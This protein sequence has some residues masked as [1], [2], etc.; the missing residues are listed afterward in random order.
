LNLR[1]SARA[2]LQAQGVLAW[3][4]GGRPAGSSSGDAASAT[5]GLPPWT[6]GPPSSQEPA[7][8]RAGAWLAAVAVA[9][10]RA[11]SGVVLT[12]YDGHA[13]AAANR[14]VEMYTGGRLLALVLEGPQVGRSARSLS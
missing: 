13:M 5:A 11:L 4:R 6:S 3:L 7:S 10:F 9:P 8:A 12:L 2:L 14:F 1:S